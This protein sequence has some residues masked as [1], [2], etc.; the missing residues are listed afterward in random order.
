[1]RRSTVLSL[2]FSKG[3]LGVEPKG[4]LGRYPQILDE[5]NTPIY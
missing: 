5:A 4:R 3:S 1:M 2:P